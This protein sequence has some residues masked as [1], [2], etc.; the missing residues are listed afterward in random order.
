MKPKTSTPELNQLAIY[1]A[2][3]FGRE[4]ALL[5]DQMN[6][7][8]KTWK[9][10]GFYD[11]G[12]EKGELVEGYPVLGGIDDVNKVT[13]KLAL[14][15]A[16]ADPLTRKKIVSSIDNPLIDFPVLAHPQALLGS[17]TNF[18]GRGSILTA[19][20]ILTTGIVTGEFVIINLT[21]TV[22]HDVKIGSFCSIMPG[23]NISGNVQ[24]GAGTMVGTGAKILQNLV[25]GNDCKVGAGTIVTKNFSDGITIVGV[26][27]RA[28]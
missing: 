4:T 16:I 15:V 21:A 1:G 14:V 8:E 11:D 18:F 6:A 19:G 9:L 22:G 23:C 28:I 17:V 13:N 10:V 2:G 27:G 24:L 3:G 12:I 20:C 26:P 25:I 5:V 7:V